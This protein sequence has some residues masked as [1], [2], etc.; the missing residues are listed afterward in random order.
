MARILAVPYVFFNLFLKKLIRKVLKI[1]L[2]LLIFFVILAGSLHIP[3]VQTLASQFLAGQLSE[4]TGFHTEIERVHIRWW[5][6]LSIQGLTINDTRDSLMANLEDVYIDFSPSTILDA[7]EPGI[8]EIKLQGGQLRFLTHPGNRT[9]NISKFIN[10]INNIFR[11]KKKDDEENTSQFFISEMSFDEVSLDILDLRKDSIPTGFDYTRLRFRELTGAARDFLSKDGFISFDIRYLRGVEATSGVVIDQ[12]LSNF[13][14]SSTGMEFDDLYFKSNKT[15]IKNYLRFTYEGVASLSDFNNEVTMLAR[16]DESVLDIKDLKYFTDNIPDFDD[17]IYLSGEVSGKVSDLF[18]E[19]LLVRFGNKSALFGKFTIDGLPKI[20]STFFQLSLVNSTINSRDLAPYLSAEAQQEMDKFQEVYFDADFSGYS[21]RFRTTGEFRTKIGGIEGRLDYLTENGQSR[22][23]G[24]AAL[25][26]L[27]LGV[28]LNNPEMFQKITMKGDLR[29]TGTSAA[30]ALLQLDAKIQSIGINKYNYK[31]IQTNATFGKE[32]FKGK[33]KISDPNLQM[34]VNGTLDLRNHKDSARMQVKLD[35]AKLQ[36]LH[37]AQDNFILHGEVELDTKGTDVDKVEGIARFKDV[38][39]SLDERTLAV[40]NFFFQSVFAND[41]RMISLNSDLLVASISGQFQAKEVYR[42]INYLIKDYIAILTNSPLEEYEEG[43]LS[44]QE[45]NMDLNMSLYDINPILKLFVP[46]LEISRNTLVEGAFYQSTEETIFN[47]YAGIDTIRYGGKTFLENDLDFNTSKSRSSREVIAACYINSKEQQLSQQVIFNNL[48]AQAIWNNAAIDFQLGLEELETES[49]AKISS[50]IELSPTQTAIIFDPS[51]IKILENFWS[52]DPENSIVIS[53]GQVD[54]DNL[55]LS[56]N[57]QFLALNGRINENPDEILSFEINDVSLDFLNTFDTKEYSGR[58]NGIF[59]FNNLLQ[60]TGA[61][62]SLRV[63]SLTVNHF[64]IGNMEAAT[65]FENDKINLSLTNERDARKNIEVV[66]FISTANDQLSL[67]GEFK[68][69]RLDIAEPF[70]SEYISELDGTLSGALKMGGTL[71]RPIV[72]GTATIKQGTLL[73]N[74][75]KTRY[76]VDGVVNFSPNEINFQGL[77]L[78]DAYNHRANMS[79]GISHEGFRNFNLDINAN[80]S[81]FQVLN[82]S[83]KDNSLFYGNAYASG[84]LKVFGKPDNLDVTAKVSTQP[85][86]QIYI[87]L[88]DADTQV[89]EDFITII[90]IRDTTQAEQTNELIDK[91]EIDNVRMNLVIDVTPDAYT[92]IQIDPRTG[93]N[94]QGR[95]KGN[96]SLNIDT[97]GNFSMTGD[98]EIVDAKYNFSLY[99]IIN[100]QF[101]IQPGGRISWYGDPY[102]GVLNITA[103]YEE[104]VSLT[105]LQTSQSSSAIEDAQLYRRY[106]VKVIMDLN[107]PLLSPNI[108]FDFD[109]SE[110]PEGEAQTTISAFKNRIA[111][112]EQEKNRQV[113]S[114]IMTRSFSPEGQFIGAGIGFSNLSQLVSSQ[115]NALISQV[116][117]NLEINIDLAS[118]DETALETFQL[119]VAYT[120]LDGRLRVSRD[121]SFTDPQGNADIGSIAG[122]WQAEYLITDDGRYRIRI[123]NKNNFNT[124][125]S[126]NLAERVNTY[127]V[128]LSQTLLFSSFKELFQNLGKRKSE[129]MLINDSDDYLRYPSSSTPP[130]SPDPL[131]PADSLQINIIESRPPEENSQE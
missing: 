102:E 108:D 29:G 51:E 71:Q 114:I 79:G 87:P 40:D 111:N 95:G 112:D 3:F 54:V 41:T 13:T 116:D 48:S 120:F 32:F 119:S 59:A 24:Q 14:Y 27:D 115:L 43:S 129:R 35:T 74:Y 113:F 92:E 50:Q 63:D 80:L 96:L 61:Y 26:Q 57:G 55:K 17:Q 131:A 12:M 5:D 53:Q 6:A 75:L 82:T 117:Q 70:L 25:K 46:S 103:T 22:Y 19:E 83:L 101:A 45:Y 128:S 65:Y 122:D 20:D 109:F 91:L 105:S 47:F 86:T 68:E 124:F 99:N 94:I 56:N 11:K 110:F 77:N 58:A 60:K 33:L 69:T 39:V 78:T 9:P 84:T 126:L 42:D 16:L 23:Y 107:G 30:E 10:E 2:Y 67:E 1:A 52:F 100:R 81:N 66:G 90:N 64:L 72:N 15:V 7:N 31:S 21:T 88:S 49:F 104:N 62:G 76:T 127:G 44:E 98:Y 28:L 38:M 123:Y 34:E 4:R 37:L 121:G 93:E 73:V 118:F 85:K 125:T 97:Q 18:S 8:D 89:Q 106:P 36:P 130:R